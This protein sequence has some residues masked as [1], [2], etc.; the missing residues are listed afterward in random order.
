[1]CAI[2]NVLAAKVIK[3][4][5]KKMWLGWNIAGMGYSTNAQLF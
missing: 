1:M 2:V 5:A 4:R 3:R